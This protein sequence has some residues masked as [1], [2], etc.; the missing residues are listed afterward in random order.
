M[1][2]SG[3]TDGTGWMFARQT[4]SG[5][6]ASRRAT[7]IAGPYVSITTSRPSRLRADR[8]AIA[9]SAS[10]RSLTGGATSTSATS[11]SAAATSRAYAAWRAA[12]PGGMSSYRLCMTPRSPMR[13]RACA[14]PAGGASRRGCVF[15]VPSSLPLS[16]D[17]LV[18]L[19]ERVDV[20]GLERLDGAERPGQV[21][22]ARDVLAH[23][24]RLD[25]VARARADRED[26]VGAHEDRGRAM[27]GE[28]LDDAAPD[29][30]VA[31]ERE[32]ADRDLATELVRHRGH[33]AGDRL[34]VDRPRGRV[35]AVRMGDAT[36]VGHLAVDEAVR[37]GVARR[38]EVALDQVA[39]EV[40]DHDRVGVEVVVGD[41]A[42]LDDHE[43]VAGDAGGEV[44]ARPRDELVA[45]QLGVEGAHLVA[46]GGDRVSHGPAPPCRSAAA[47]A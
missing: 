36:D 45:G 24:R 40:A 38:H 21:D 30:L 47:R 27:A 18:A 43:L 9:R 25:S 46:Q 44:P 12:M 33:H 10:S 41:A 39:G 31:D 6:S 7:R 1:S 16:I 15:M 23:D 14:I 5:V 28:R 26:A 19:P 2:H 20:L 42:G 35:R 34:A 11:L 13:G 3:V 17:V 29:L 4:G 32:R 37:R 8:S 22:R